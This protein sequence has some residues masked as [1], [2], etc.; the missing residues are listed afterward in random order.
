MIT[1]RDHGGTIDDFVPVSGQWALVMEYK[2]LGMSSSAQFWYLRAVNLGTRQVISLAQATG[3]PATTELPFYTISG[4]RIVWDQVTAAGVKVLDMYDLGTRRS[5]TVPLPL[6][7]YPVRPILVG[8]QLVFLDNST[9]PHRAR[10]E[11]DTG[12]GQLMRY[13]LSTGQLIRLDSTNDARNPSAND[14]LI[15]WSD[16]TAGGNNSIKITPIA[17][18]GI[19]PLAPLAIQAFLSDSY[20]AWYDYNARQLF[21][22]SFAEHRTVQLTVAGEPDLRA[23]YALCGATFYYALPPDVDGDRSVIRSLDLSQ[24]FAAH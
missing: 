4:N 22:Y 17:G 24:A 14:S 19:K 5:S 21:A 10:E 20:A 16:E 15:A 23:Q 1:L 12:G 7:V 3:P 2:Q 18:H 13:D 9:D 8:D 6:G 11:F